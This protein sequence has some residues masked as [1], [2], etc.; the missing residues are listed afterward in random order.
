MVLTQLPDDG[1]RRPTP[2]AVVQA[3]ARWRCGDAGLCRLS[4]FVV[5]KNLPN[6]DVYE[7]GK[8]SGDG[9]RERTGEAGRVKKE[10]EEQVRQA[11]WK[12][13]NREK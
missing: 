11:G 1:A 5:L 7:W 8:D 13:K 2:S 6:S 3:D 4:P 9:A 12:T 10:N